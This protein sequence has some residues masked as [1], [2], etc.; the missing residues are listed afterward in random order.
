MPADVAL[1]PER[2]QEYHAERI[3]AIREDPKRLCYEEAYQKFA[4]SISMLNYVKIKDKFENQDIFASNGTHGHTPTSR[5]NYG[6]KQ[7]HHG[8]L[9]QWH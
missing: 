9:P 3:E 8:G 6:V 5:V 7:L 4:T 1:M 2:Y